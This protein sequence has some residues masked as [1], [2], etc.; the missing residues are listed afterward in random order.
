MRKF[1][2]MAI[3]TLWPIV[4][5]A[6]SWEPDLE[7]NL[8]VTLTGTVEMDVEIDFGTDDWRGVQMAFGV[9]EDELEIVGITLGAASN[10]LNG[11]TGPAF[12]GGNTIA[13]CASTGLRYRQLGMVADLI[14]A[15]ITGSGVWFVLEIAAG[16]GATASST[17]D[18]E[19]KTNGAENCTPLTAGTGFIDTVADEDTAGPFDPTAGDFVGDVEIVD[20]E[21]IRGDTVDDGAV[22]IADPVSALGVLFSTGTFLCDDAAD[23]NDDGDVNIADPIYILQYLFAMGTAPPT[24]FGTTE[25]QDDGTTT[26]SLDCDSYNGC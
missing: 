5:M 13:D 1:L 18:V 2:I 23:S 11:G 20:V 10:A 7:D 25:C 16:P 14:N 17:Y 15:E 26:D 3:V 19:L 22:N 4:G 8:E 6:Q 9:D 21:F 24:P 12:F